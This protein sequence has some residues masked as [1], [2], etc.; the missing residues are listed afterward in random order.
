MATGGIGGVH[1]DVASTG[2]VSADLATLARCPVAVVCAGAKAVLDLA[3]TME[4]LES[5][6]VPVYGFGVDE[7]PAFYR[8]SSGLAVD[9]RFDDVGELASAV[10]AHFELGSGTGVVVANPVPR[11]HELP[12]EL[13]DR[14]IAAALAEAERAGVRGRAVTPFLLETLEKLTGGASVTTNRVLLL[15]NATLAGRLASALNG[16]R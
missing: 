2:D 12:R 3:R 4:A 9:H 15:A 8:R 14:A 5:L 11:E 16:A 10:L 1:R 6:G 7:L 13:Y